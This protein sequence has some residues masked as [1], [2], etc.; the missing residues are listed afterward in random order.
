MPCGAGSRNLELLLIKINAKSIFSPGPVP[1]FS[2]S[3]HLQLQLE[4]K[5]AHHPEEDK[6]AKQN[7]YVDPIHLKMHKYKNTQTRPACRSL[8]AS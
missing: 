6:E 3:V 8:T 4:D 1:Y 5:V 7:E 2:L